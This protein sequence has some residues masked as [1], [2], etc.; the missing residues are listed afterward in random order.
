[1]KLT[2]PTPCPK[3]TN[4][5]SRGWWTSVAEKPAPHPLSSLIADEWTRYRTQWTGTGPWTSI[6]FL[7]T[8][9]QLPF[10]CIF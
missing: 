5:T 3:Y 9:E 8:E 1:M 6:G 2:R 10:K 7:V 4:D